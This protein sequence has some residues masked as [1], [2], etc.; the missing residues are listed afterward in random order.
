MIHYPVSMDISVVA[1]S[2][3]VHVHPIASIVNF[4]DS[5][6]ERCQ[7]REFCCERCQ[8]YWLQCKCR[9]L[10]KYSESSCIVRAFD[11][12]E[13]ALL[14]GGRGGGEHPWNWNQTLTTKV[15]PYAVNFSRNSISS[16]AQIVGKRK[17]R[18]LS[19]FR[20]CGAKRVQYWKAKFRKL[21]IRRVTIRNW[22]CVS[23][24][25]IRKTNIRSLL[26]ENRNSEKISFL[27][28]LT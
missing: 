3:I 24:K 18:S 22:K 14:R 13:P 16:S 27:W 15:R 19:W 5:N 9:R 20:V 6:R 4:P 12:V 25:R 8:L 7:S 23:V 2:N 10:Y 11:H 21:T 28:I 17:Q 26:I 1:V